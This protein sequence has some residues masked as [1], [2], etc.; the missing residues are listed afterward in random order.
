MAILGVSVE[1]SLIRL[2]QVLIQLT[3][4]HSIVFFHDFA[5]VFVVFKLVGVT[6][7]ALGVHC[8]P[9]SSQGVMK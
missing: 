2:F 8:S 7:C 5:D 3:P 1:D 9:R 6:F 4:S